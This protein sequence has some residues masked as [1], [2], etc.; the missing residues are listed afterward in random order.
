MVHESQIGL[1]KSSSRLNR[2]SRTML[3]SRGC[4]GN[5]EL[6][7]AWNF[8]HARFLPP[9]VVLPC[10]MP[11]LMYFHS[12]LQCVFLTMPFSYFENHVDRAPCEGPP[13]WGVK[14]K[15]ASVAF[16]MLCT[17][18]D[19]L[20]T[21]NWPSMDPTMDPTIDPIN[22]HTKR[23]RGKNFFIIENNSYRVWTLCVNL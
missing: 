5:L 3:N 13:H 15:R 17:S 10:P 4:R 11:R 1:W 16:G 8:Q 2:N 19:P 9:P 14:K 7:L 20:L 6:L 21:L 12:I 22:S 23:M 18:I